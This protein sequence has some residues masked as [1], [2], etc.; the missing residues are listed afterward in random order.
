MI[1]SAGKQDLQFSDVLMKAHAAALRE[2]TE[3]ARSATQTLLSVPYGEGDLEKLDVYVPSTPSLDLPLVI[4]LHGGYWQFLSKEESG[5]IA[6][7]LVQKDV[8]VVAVG[9]DTASG[10]SVDVMVSQV[11]RSVVS[12]MQQYSHI[13]GLY[14]CAHSSGAHLAAM[15]LSTDWSQY[16][17]RPPIKGALLVSGLYD[18][19]PVLSGGVYELLKMTEEEAIRNSPI[20]LVEQLKLSS[21]DCDIAVA[22]AQNDSP[23]FRKQS[24]EYFKGPY[25]R[26][27]T[28]FIRLVVISSA[29]QASGVKVTLVDVPNCDHF[30]VIEQCVSGD[31]QLIQLLLKLIGRN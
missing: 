25:I 5:F 24:E 27:S 22:M 19:L 14:L 18:L 2:G 28:H 30:S 12:V 31:Y 10:G 29:L 21:S 1:D 17:V 9:Y 6:L 23:D 4:Y 16:A 8:A 20:R 13:S 15:L 3:L 11:R 7:P 26:S